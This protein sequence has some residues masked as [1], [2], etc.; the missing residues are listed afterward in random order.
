MWDG[1]WSGYRDGLMSSVLLLLYG[2][3]VDDVPDMMWIV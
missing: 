1:L 3:Q 2:W